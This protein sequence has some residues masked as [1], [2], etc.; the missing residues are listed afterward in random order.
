[1]A[2]TTA[3]VASTTAEQK[4]RSLDQEFFRKG[5]LIALFS[6]LMYGI[7]TAFIT[8]G[9]STSL[10]LGWLDSIDPAGF[11]A[12]FILP[13]VAS[14]I[15]DSCSALWALGI[16]AKQG[17]LADF[18]RTV[19]TKPGIIMIVSALVGGPIATVAYII[20]LS[21]AG[22]IV[23]P[24]AALNPAIGAILSRILFKQEL[25]LRK[26]I[27]I[28]V[29]VFAGLMIGSTSLTGDASSNL[30]FGLM[31]AFIAALG[32]GA[33]GCI[34]GYASCMI[35]TQ[36]GITIRQ[37]VS[38]ISELFVLLPAMA[39]IGGVPMGDT[40]GYVTSALTDL[41]TIACFIVAGFAAYKSFAS[42]YRGN[43]MCGTA[44]G[45]ACNGTYTFV[46]PL[47]TWIIVGVIM[48][49]DGYALAPIAWAAAFVMIVG[50]VII[51]VDPLEYLGKK[52]EA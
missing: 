3:T 16:T 17:K 11:L 49:I 50:I 38:G 42:W 29:C 7:Y 8:A 48:N 30:G 15:N 4:K 2:S 37:C 41:P 21:Q 10:W 40:I 5:I 20:A 43:S 47:T 46:A 51:A 12:I 23:V 18:G 19:P 26:M 25:G 45:M 32:W 22:T 31:L 27:G 36:I 35:D 52:E 1:M 24:I 44:L 33:E 14:A 6:S 34:A 9:G 39:L 13:T 28:A